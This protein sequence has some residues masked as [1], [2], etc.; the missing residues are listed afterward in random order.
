MIVP[1][2]GFLAHLDWSLLSRATGGVGS[3]LLAWVPFLNPVKLPSGARLWMFLPLA[4]CI[5]VVYRA[6]RARSLEKLPRGTLV[7]FVNITVGMIAI[8]AAFYLV[9]K[10]ALFLGP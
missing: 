2:A 9:N 4:L 1:P 7:T 6:T 5:A 3:A 10:A 8:A